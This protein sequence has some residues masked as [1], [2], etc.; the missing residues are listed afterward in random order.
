MG[1]VAPLEGARCPRKRRH[2]LH[3][4]LI[5]AI[6]AILCGANGWVWIAQFGRS[7]RAWFQ[8]FWKL[9]HGIPSRIAFGCL[10]GL[11]SPAAFDACFR[12]RVE[13]IRA[14]RSGELIAVDGKTQQ[15][16]HNR[17]AGL[18]ALHVVSAWAA[19]NRP[20]FGQVATNAKSNEITVIPRLLALLHIQGSCIVTINATG[21]QAKIAALI[22][23]RGGDDLL[24]L[25]GNQGMLAAAFEEAF[26][27]ADAKYDDGLTSQALK[28]LE[29]GQ[30]RRERRCYR[31]LGQ[32]DGLSNGAACRT[33]TDSP[34][35][36]PTASATANS[37]TRQATTTAASASMRRP[38]PAA[39]CGRR[40]IQMGHREQ[41]ALVVGRRL[42]RGRVARARRSSRPRE[43]PP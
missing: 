17:G 20:V 23:T 31:T 32:L 43:L 10:F 4:R 18:A 41:L 30:G 24:A 38:S 12:A 14:L 3:E 37:P 35:S 7:K 22:I 40:G 27:D 34:W 2:I 15:S 36:S 5:I 39:V 13:S 25:K 19:S 11:L 1:Y 9:P 8:G 29:Q 16:P 26:I 21:C 33:S 6:T 42:P 28:T